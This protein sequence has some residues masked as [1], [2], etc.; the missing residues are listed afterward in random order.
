MQ[1]HEYA[2]LEMD[3]ISQLLTSVDLILLSLKSRFYFFPTIYYRNSHSH[4]GGIHL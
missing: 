1:S 3:M 4:I 2:I